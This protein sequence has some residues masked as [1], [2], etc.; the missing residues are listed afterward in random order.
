MTHIRQSVEFDCPLHGHVPAK[1]RKLDIYKFL[2]V[3]RTVPI[4]T[5]KTKELDLHYVY[6]CRNIK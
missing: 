4:P 3:K 6:V 5:K 2:R 1:M